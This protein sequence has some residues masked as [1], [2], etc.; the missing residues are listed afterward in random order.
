MVRYLLPP[1]T[2][3]PP[4]V[5]SSATTVNEGIFYCHMYYSKSFLA[6]VLI[7]TCFPQQVS[8]EKPGWFLKY[9]F[10]PQLPFLKNSLKAY[11]QFILRF[12]RRLH[13]LSIWPSSTPN[14]FLTQ[15][16]CIWCSFSLNLFFCLLKD[17]LNGVPKKTEN[18]G[19]YLFKCNR[20]NPH[21]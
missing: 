10:Y 12:Y 4:S 14:S 20:Q 3:H 16:I 8:T 9:T 18:E 11:T 19:S 5:I 17:T 2:S 13:C 1:N 21:I 15:D 7:S 6:S